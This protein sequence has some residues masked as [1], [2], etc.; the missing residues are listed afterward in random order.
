MLWNVWSSAQNS[1]ELFDLGFRLRRRRHAKNRCKVVYCG[2]Q[3]SVGGC[4]CVILAQFAVKHVGSAVAQQC[5]DGTKEGISAQR[6]YLHSRHAYDVCFARN[7]FRRIALVSVLAEVE[8]QLGV[9]F[10]G[11]VH[12][13]EARFVFSRGGE[14]HWQACAVF[15]FLGVSLGRRGDGWMLKTPCYSDVWTCQHRSAKTWHGISFGVRP[16]ARD[17]VPWPPLEGA[18]TLI[19]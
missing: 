12:T 15:G 19:F 17:R 8:G 3:P 6:N 10:V 18:V 11:L 1:Y 14:S 16:V 9:Y 2:Q 4:G 7:V 13:I 5:V